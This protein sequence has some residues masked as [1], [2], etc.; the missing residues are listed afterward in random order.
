MTESSLS[1]NSAETTRLFYR[2]WR[3]RFAI[4]LL[5]G[6]LI[7]GSIALIPA[8]RGSASTVVDAV[9]IAVY[10]L[11]GIVT[12]V[13]FSYVV[14][15][16]VFL[17]SIYVLGISELILYGI[18]GDGLFFF[19][20]LIIFSTMLL[21][22]RAGI[23][24]LILNII[25]FSVFG[26]LMLS[27]RV[28]PLN[29]SVLPSKIDDWVSAGVVLSMF[30][31][32]III[33]FQ[34]LE[35]EFLESQK[36]IDI[37]LNDLKNERTNLENKVFE[38]TVQLGKINKIGR[39]VTAILDP[40]ELLKQAAHLIEV[41]F[42]CYYTAFFLLDL[43]E[44]WADLKEATGEAGRILRENKYRLDVDGK[45]AVSVAI[46]T[47]QAYIV[48][49]A[50]TKAARPDNPLLPYSRSQIAMPLIVGDTVL[51]ALEMHATKANAFS[52]QDVEAY[53]NMANE[54]AIALENSRLFLRAQQS[55]SEM[56]ATQRQYLQGAWQSLTN[57]RR[58]DYA[59]G[60]NDSDDNKEIKIPLV[61]RD[62]IIGQ[63][64]LEN[65]AEWSPE[66]KTLIESITT[67]ASL[68]L[69]NARLV[70]ESQSIAAREKLANELITKIWASTNMDNILQTTVRELGRSLEASEVVIEVSMGTEDE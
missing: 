53:Q 32:V 26:W 51:G 20:G 35:Q 64:Y 33:G 28:T 34:R 5:V 18:L 15:M 67:Q 21:S 23:A 50:G 10:I 24:A 57:H 30:G 46:R 55:L 6:V 66:Q 61:L 68:A 38:R 31:L 48:Q 7:L 13:R 44:H 29:Q 69:E 60:D 14:R 56:R 41:E 22:P 27:G 4:P 16:S 70:E 37:T 49:E 63:V 47:K 42:D 45:S 3:E 2:N 39:A 25:T 40:D 36:Q 65:S 17:L 8:L 9:F 11:T 1:R 43:S 58:L 54:I 19:L 59:L 52:P 62:Q 12:I